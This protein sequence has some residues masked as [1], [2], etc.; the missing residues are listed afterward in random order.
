M[1]QYFYK[2]GFWGFPLLALTIV[3]GVLIARRAYQ[4]STAKRSL[5][6]H[7]AESVHMILFWG[8]LSAIVGILGQCHGTYNAAGA[9]ARAAEISPQVVAMGFS[10]SLTTTLWGLTLLFCAAIAW[11]ALRMRIRRLALGG[12]P[13]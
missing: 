9:I 6:P 13:A 2:C 3:L 4:V 1:L 10:E 12:Q 7:V 8:V 5:E 11:F